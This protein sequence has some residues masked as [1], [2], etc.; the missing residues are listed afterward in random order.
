LNNLEN[1]KKVL[2]DTLEQDRSVQNVVLV[3]FGNLKEKLKQ[4]PLFSKKYFANLIEKYNSNCDSLDRFEILQTIYQYSND[5]RFIIVANNKIM[6]GVLKTLKSGNKNASLIAFS[7][8]EN[9]DSN[10]QSD[11][12]CDYKSYE[13]S[14]DKT[15]IKNAIFDFDL[16]DN[17]Q[18]IRLNSEKDIDDY[19]SK[20]PSEM[21]LVIMFINDKTSRTEIDTFRNF[22]NLNK[23][24]SVRFLIFELKEDQLN[25]EYSYIGV[26][27]SYLVVNF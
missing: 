16:S 25:I 10:S 27:L 19:F 15:L 23:Q 7:C 14:L 8:K 9:N 24:E 13:E 4:A 1:H 2:L 21:S 17:N 6:D 26:Y 5:N 12:H 22:S 3:N 18:Y 20:I 11:H